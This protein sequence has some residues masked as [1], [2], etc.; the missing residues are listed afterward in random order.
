MAGP[1]KL[2][3]LGWLLAVTLVAV[4]LW[5]KNELAVGAA[6]ER[7]RRVPAPSRAA[8]WQELRGGRLAPDPN[9]DGDS[10][11]IHHT[12]GDHI[13]RLYFVD[14]CEKRR[15][16]QNRA[17]LTEQGAYFG[18]LTESAVLKLGRQAREEVLGLLSSQPF[19][20]F[21]RWEPVYDERRHYA[22]VMVTMPD[23]SNRWLAEW[24]VE[25]GLA[26]LHTRGADLS[27]STP[28]YVARA[29]L[30]AL[31]KSARLARRGGWGLSGALAE[32]RE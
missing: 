1:R 11:L 14:C 16:P 12:G 32:D 20:A 6:G 23:G 29:R 24:L 22:H 31:E 2:S 9:N 25:R 30:L 18:G 10:F 3:T 5:L 27:D 13:M 7:G 26:R 19:T 4:S 15:H 8:Q 28:E 21:T 17:R